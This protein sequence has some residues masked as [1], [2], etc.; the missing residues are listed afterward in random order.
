M[1]NG[2]TTLNW[3]QMN[4]RPAKIDIHGMRV[5]V[6][7]EYVYGTTKYTS[8]WEVK[9]PVHKNCM[10]TRSTVLDAAHFGEAGT[11]YYLGCLVSSAF[12]SP[13]KEDRMRHRRWRPTVANITEYLLD[14]GIVT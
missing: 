5:T 10:K 13:Y 1:T 12:K 3:K 9:C 6:K 2:W 4:D 8:R 7:P 11:S 14:K